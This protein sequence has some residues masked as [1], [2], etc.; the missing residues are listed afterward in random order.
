[1][2]TACLFLAAKVEETPKPLKEV[3]RVAYLVQHKNEYDDAVKRIHQK[4]RLLFCFRQNEF[5]GY[6]QD[7]FVWV[8]NIE[9]ESNSV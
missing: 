4:A 1:M 3:V 6:I 2:A 7:V 5:S 9:I 8:L